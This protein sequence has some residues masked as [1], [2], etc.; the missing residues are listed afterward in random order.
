MY[1]HPKLHRACICLGSNIDPESNMKKAVM[2]LRELSNIE[3]LSACY[4]TVA[5]GSSGPN[6]L[7]M[8]A[9]LVTAMPPDALKEQVLHPIEQQLG[10]VRMQDKNAPRTIDLDLIIYDNQVLDPE[11]WRRVHLA[12]PFSEL[13][14]ELQD[15]DSGKSLKD[16]AAELEDRETA[17]LRPE[18]VF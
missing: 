10:R 3:G 12:L 2:L 15:P 4:E 8:A 18:L 1:Q 17:L 9:C 16:I 14:P 7:N 6:F 11:L 13:L 5:V